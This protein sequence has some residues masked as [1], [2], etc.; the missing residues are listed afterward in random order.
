MATYNE[1]Y[2]YGIG[3]DFIGQASFALTK[4]AKDVLNEDPGTT[5]HSQR[6]KWADDVLAS[7]ES[8][9]EKMKWAILQNATLQGNIPNN[10]D[11][12]IQFVV[13]SNVNT[14]ATNLYTA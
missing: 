1:I 12:D 10:T 9:L 11:N 8:M 4:A 6:V 2:D 7:P 3:A 13:N 14:F 5:Y